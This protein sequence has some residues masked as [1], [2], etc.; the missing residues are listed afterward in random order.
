MPQHS[1]HVVAK[2]IYSF[3][4]GKVLN[5]QT[6]KTGLALFSQCS[7]SENEMAHF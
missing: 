6:H 7:K 3:A 4:C 2:D 1:Y 5:T